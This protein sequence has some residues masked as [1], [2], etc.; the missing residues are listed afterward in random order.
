VIVQL[1]L[2]TFKVDVTGVS[3]G[4]EESSMS[5]ISTTNKSLVLPVLLPS[6]AALLET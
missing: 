1:S 3:T 5:G 6:Q 4:L 2:K